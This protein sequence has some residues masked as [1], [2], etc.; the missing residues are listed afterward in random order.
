ML[1]SFTHPEVFPN[2]YEC[3]CSAEHKGRYSEECGKPSSSGA[4]LTSII[5]FFSCYGSQRC[6]KTAWLQTFFQISSF[7]LNK[8]RFPQVL[9]YFSVSKWWQNVGVNYPFNHTS[10][11]FNINL[12]GPRMI[13]KEYSAVAVVTKLVRIWLTDKQHAL[14]SVLFFILWIFQQLS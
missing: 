2:L 13:L 9:N 4:P 8:H 11:C 12:I 3:L 1:S 7:V 5:F 14:I 6:P 10:L